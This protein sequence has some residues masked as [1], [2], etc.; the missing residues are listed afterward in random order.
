M[1]AVEEVERTKVHEWGYWTNS[2]KGEHIEES[3]TTVVI[4]DYISCKSEWSQSS[5]QK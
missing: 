3:V 2:V 1:Q 5:A 4:L